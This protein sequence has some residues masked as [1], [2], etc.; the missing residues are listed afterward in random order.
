MY[1]CS[2]FQVRKSSA[3][4]VPNSSKYCMVSFDIINKQT[5]KVRA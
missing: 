4:L 1:Y 5:L 3:N 2:Q